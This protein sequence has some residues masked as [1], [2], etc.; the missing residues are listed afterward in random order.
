MWDAVSAR[1]Q[2]VGLRTI[3]PDQRGYS[4]GARP[5]DV[6][7][8]TMPEFARDAVAILDSL[9]I[10]QAHVVGHDWGS[11]V[12]WHLCAD[13]ADRVR[14][15]TAVAVPH[16]GAM[17]AAR[18]IDD[19]KQRSSYFILFA[20]E[21]KAEDVLLA[22][23]AQRLRAL[24]SPLAPEIA[25][26][27]VKPMLDRAALTAALNWY[28]RMSREPLAGST[29]PVTYVWGTEDPAVS[30]AAA[31]ACSEFVAPGVDF[32]FVVLPGVSHW[33]PDQAPGAVTAAILD[34]IG[35]M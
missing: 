1:L 4:P 23:D 22:D 16:P 25:D 33:V 10:E 31:Y 12:G 18:R 26:I 15:Y 7:S 30:A 35:T 17:A 2:A 14:S 8:Y 20:T 21:G 9:G 19:Q 32:R 28:R 5:S 29:V 3:A 24:F 6:D 27:Y 13:H 34:R 11:A